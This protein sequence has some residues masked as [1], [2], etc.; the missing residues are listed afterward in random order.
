MKL[1]SNPYLTSVSIVESVVIHNNSVIGAGAVVV[2]DVP[3]SKTVA[4]VLAK[5][6]SENNSKNLIQNV[7]TIEE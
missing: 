6:I 4:G 2:K 1:D 5:V 3:E 7:W